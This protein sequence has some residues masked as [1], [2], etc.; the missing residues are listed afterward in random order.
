MSVL[1]PAS[2][3]A[4]DDRLRRLIGRPPHRELERQP[5]VALLPWGLLI[6]DFLDRDGLTLER[7]ATEYTGSWMFGY[8]SALRRAGVRTVIVCVSGRIKQRAVFLHRPSGATVVALP[9]PRAYRLLRRGMVN[10]YGRTAGQTFGSLRGPRL[11]IAP[12]LAAAKEVAPYLSTPLTDLAREIRGQGCKAVLCQ[13][14]E[15]PR[16]DACVALG[17]LLDVPTFATFQGG[18]YRRWK[19]EHVVRPLAVRA[20][21]GLIIGAAT[22]ARRVSE[23]YA[24]GNGRLARIPNP[25]DTDA[26]RPGDQDS[27]RTRLGIPHEAR[28]VAWHGRVAIWKKGLDVLL[29]AWQLLSQ[30]QNDVYLLLV[31]AGRDA[32][33]LRSRLEAAATKNVVWIDRLLERPDE[34]RSL[35]AAAD[36]YAF[37]SRHEGFP[38]GLAEALGCG[39]PAVACDAT[40]VEDILG[41]LEGRPGTIVPRDDPAGFAAA[42][43]DLLADPQT[44]RVLRA[45]ARARAEGSFSLDAVGAELRRV[46]LPAGS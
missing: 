25:I 22:E 37:P 41:P 9:T 32:P 30:R 23:T 2:F 44:R 31:G 4:S 17:K 16:F 38:V 36:V 12:L 35:L 29:E 28:V 33:E 34:I 8:A 6:E 26:W 19:L 24:I 20:A 42:L 3:G 45:R 7:F 15:F 39:L 40:G 18:D 13:E 5:A 46:L 10:P 43:A 27:A 1:S 21:E 11:A 14:Y